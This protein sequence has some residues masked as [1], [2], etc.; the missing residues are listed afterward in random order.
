MHGRCTRMMVRFVREEAGMT[1]G[2]VVIMLVLIGVMGAGLLTFVST[3]LNTVVEVNQGQRAFEMADAGIQ[4]ARKQ[5]RDRDSNPSR[6]D[7][8]GADDLDWAKDDGKRL[9]MSDDEVY[10]RIRSNTP[11]AGYFT[12]TSTG[13]ARDARRRVEAVFYSTASLGGGGIPAW[14]TPGGVRIQSQ[15]LAEG[16]SFFAGGDIVLE[17]DPDTTGIG[18]DVL[19]DWYR[20]PYNTTRRV[21]PSTGDPYIKAG[22][23]AEGRVSCEKDNGSDGV[24][25]DGETAG[26]LYYDSTTETK[27]VAKEPPTLQPQAEDTITYPFPREVNVDGLLE[28]AGSGSPNL[29]LSSGGRIP[30]STDRRVVF[31]DANGGA[32]AF[33]G[34]S[35]FNGILVIRCGELDV[36]E[37]VTFNAI[38][39][40]LRGSGVGC[41]SKGRLDL[42]EAL[43][44][45]GTVYVESDDERAIDMNERPVIGPLP[46]GYEDLSSLAFTS[47]VELVSWREL[48]Q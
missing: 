39:I 34:S 7:G 29:Y 10:V 15:A 36:E 21:D 40:L 44:I 13:E 28:E 24:C 5:I 14:Y 23:A 2:L 1:M 30:D 25:G 27:F 48:Y 33:D 31:V 11:S 38:V 43:T 37:G 20:P 3:D 17:G 4:A 45:N 42:E 6:Y 8:A 26:I 22:L 47:S 18:D 35:T 41:A 9:S 16:V 32:V 46:D 19:G 12:V